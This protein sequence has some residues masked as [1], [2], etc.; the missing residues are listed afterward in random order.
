MVEFK[1]E[2]EDLYEILGIDSTSSLNDVSY[3]K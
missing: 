3:N 1:I 2:N